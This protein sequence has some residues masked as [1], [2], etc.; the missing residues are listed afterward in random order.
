MNR[1]ADIDTPLISVVIPCFNQAKFLGE[2]IESVLA[3]TYR[4]FE[5]F[6]IDDGSTDGTPDIAKRYP[7]VRYSKQ[8]NQ[9][10]AAS[11]NAGIQAS[12]G[13]YLVFLDADDRLLPDALNGGLRCI[14][15][16]SDC[17]FVSGGHRRID[18]AGVVIEEPTPPR[19]EKDHYLAFLRGN[20]VGMHGAVMYQR[21]FLTRRGGFDSSLPAC[22][23]Y[24][25]YLRLARSHPVHCHDA[26]VAE[27]RTYDS[28]M[29]ADVTFMLPTVLKVLQSQ[30]KYLKKDRRRIEAYRTGVRYWQGLYAQ[31][32]VTRWS[33]SLA[34]GEFVK[35]VRG[36][37]AMSRHAP[38]Q[39]WRLALRRGARAA[40]PTPILRLLARLR[41]Y[42]Y[43]PPVG[44][45]R[46]GDLRRL[47][48]ISREFGYDRG[49]PIDRYY[50]ENFLVRQANDIQGRVLEIGD[51][52]YTQKFGGDR[53]RFR[54][55]LHMLEGNPTATIIGDLTCADHIP[56]DRF[57]C[58][59]LTQT[60]HLIY[61]IRLAM[62]TIY[63]ILK[64]GGVVLATF[65]GI[66]QRSM[67][68]WADSWYW[69]FTTLSAQ[70][71]FEEVFPKASIRV[72]AFG[73][74]L[75]A[76]AFLYGLALQELRTEELDH[77]DCHYELLITVRAVKPGAMCEY[78]KN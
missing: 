1:K 4:N 12:R 63:R 52:S 22:E 17:A 55:V 18:E 54:D 50:I 58:L 25:L 42:P 29:S 45:I 77:Y 48:P 19:N 37:L 51:D 14:E 74:V 32:F 66:S 46:F 10:L 64:P 57:D 62:Q 5:I 38:K 30:R 61:D 26:V 73:N 7:Q 35:V 24:D 34:R 69:N 40:L 67:D 6:V 76:T 39:F 16:H 60:L 72:E 20:Y 21:Q 43:H 2:A 70:R 59:I 8:M 13:R 11:R 65:P 23:D 44:R 71:I 33:R 3:Q 49:L 47:T 31:E 53:V 78:E 56:S 9:G 28:S 75:V 15:K 41:G 27:Y 36:V 68:Q